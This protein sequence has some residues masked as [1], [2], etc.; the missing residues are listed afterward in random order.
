MPV[1]AGSALARPPSPLS[2]VEAGWRGRIGG[3]AGSSCLAE[4]GWKADSRNPGL[5][6]NTLCKGSTQ[7][8]LIFLNLPQK[9]NLVIIHPF[10]LSFDCTFSL[11]DARFSEGEPCRV[12]FFLEKTAKRRK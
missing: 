10:D 2:E 5:D 9:N 4:K 1:E 7:L 3:L 11:N 8:K 6:N 12:I